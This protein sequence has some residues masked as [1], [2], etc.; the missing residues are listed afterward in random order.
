MK[1]KTNINLRMM[2]LSI[3]SVCLSLLFLQQSM[4]CKST[5]SGQQTIYQF[6]AKDLDGND[7]FARK[8]PWE[9][10][11]DRQRRIRMRFGDNELP[12]AAGFVR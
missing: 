11:I 7:V 4:A 5:A 1:R 2:K 10:R 12:A 9:S 3:P 6:N 8:V